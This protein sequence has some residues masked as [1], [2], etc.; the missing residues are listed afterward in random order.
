MAKRFL[1]TINLP[2]LSSDPVSGSEGEIYY[3]T[4]TD[5][6]RFYN[7]SSWADLTSSG[8]GGGTA[9][10]SF[11]TISTPSGT[12]PV[13]DSS[14]DTL[15]FTASGGVSITGN[16]TTDT[17]EFST[18]ATPLNT[19][20]TIVSRDSDQSFDITA[21]DFDTVDSI[22]SAVGR[23]SWDDGEGTL[24]LGLKGGNVNLKIGQQETTLCY[25]G[26]GSSLSKGTVVYISGAQGQRPSISKSNASTESTSSKTFGVVAENIANGA[27]GYV[28]TFG[29]IRGLDTS[30]FTEGS[31]LWL[32]TTS[33][34]FTQTVPTQPNHSV[35]IGYCIRSHASSG[36]IF[37]K[38]QN[39]YELQELHNVLIS[40]L[41]DNHILSYDNS[42]SLWKNQALAAAIQ[43]IDGA[44]SG[45]DADLLDGQHGSY[46]APIESPALTGTPTA[47]TAS[48]LT[49]TTQIAT[50]AFVRTEISNLIDSAPSTLDTLNELAAALGDDPNY[51]TTI[52]TALGG[53]EPT[54]TAGTTSQY[55]R[56]DKSWQTLDKSAVGLSNV[57]N[58]ALSTWPGSSN[59]T[60]VGTLN[61]LTVTN[62]ITGSISGNAGTVTNGVYTTGSYSNPSWITSLSETKVLPSQ[63]SNNGK[64]LT[65]D[66]TSTS[67]AG[68]AGAVYSST[69]PTSPIVGQIWIESDVDV[70]TY[71]A[72]IL[73]RWIQTLTGSQSVFS[74][75]SSGFILSYTPGYERVYLNGVLLVPEEDYTATDGSTVTL[76]EAASSGDVIQILSPSVFNVQNVY[77]TSEVDSLIAT[78]TINSQSGTSY[79]LVLSDAGKFIEM[80]NSSAN[81]ITIPPDSSVNFPVGTK[82]DIIQFGSGIT[83]IS[84]DTGVTLNSEGGKR[85]ISNQYSSAYIIKRSSNNWILIGSLTT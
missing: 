30:A 48:A 40:S 10:D 43:E 12:S 67:W 6:V 82:I 18:N 19:A 73:R 78:K 28:T 7:G 49:N 38:I 20:S 42:T 3:N 34:L 8:G 33:G 54:I 57:E 37:V 59:I 80:T 53:K 65:T 11:T 32:S 58:T 15:S 56:G 21:V 41:A 74:G 60:T 84:P 46:Y 36:E 16:S 69:A 77:T 55:W 1:S 27:E 45:I 47:P 35:F 70:D 85:K 61:D 68:I 31:A 4:E 22:S 71:D 24:S 83:S 5:K 39:G 2:K 14:S 51:A 63:T 17:V 26:T 64:Y 75:S 62:T 72:K 29:L 23:L 79:T 52:S 81:S 9:S 66:G 25:N 44:S 76:T 50:T 13:A